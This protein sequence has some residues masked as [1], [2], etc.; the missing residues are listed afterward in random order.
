MRDA[1]P[2]QGHQALA[3]LFEAGYL[4]TMI[5]QNIDGLHQKAGIPPEKVIELHGSNAYISCLDCRSRYEWEEVLPF[6]SSHPFPSLECPRCQRCGGLLKPATISFGQA[7]PENET[8]EAFIEAGKADFLLAIGSS[9]QVY[10]AAAIPGESVRC[11]G[12]FAIINNQPTAQDFEAVF[13]LR[14]SAG[15]ILQTVADLVCAER[16][17]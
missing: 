3:R 5:T 14:G 10:P 17:A 11:G 13:L 12:T 15:E 8:R 9:L 7:M 1:E 4:K 6:F 2:N 16:I